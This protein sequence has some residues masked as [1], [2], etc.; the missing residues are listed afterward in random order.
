MRIFFASTI[1]FQVPISK[2]QSG[3]VI[4][5]GLLF[6]LALLGKLAV[7]FMVPNFT[8][9]RKFTGNHLRDCLIVGCSMAAEGEFAFV[10]A[11]DS[12][13]KGLIG[14]DLYS[15]IVLAILL[16]TIIAPFS[17]RFTITYFNKKA[18]AEVED[19]EGMI[20]KQGDIDDELKRGILKG[21]TIF[22]C[23]NTTSHA[24]WGTL[25]KLMHTLFDLGLEVIDHRSW[26]S[27]FEDTVVNEAY[28]KGDLA[29]GTN[30]DDFIQTIFD[31]VKA[32]IDQ[33]VR[34]SF[35]P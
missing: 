23:V 19:A 12:V 15:S 21:S 30:I 7:G 5:K 3:E 34:I 31:K 10:I 9:S 16:S 14:E 29:G 26:H 6:T 1:G 20:Q 27:R 25:P 11:A 2:F 35:I 32:A 22:F 33:E 17:L 24:A 13:S 28:V 4:W 8:Q 18:L